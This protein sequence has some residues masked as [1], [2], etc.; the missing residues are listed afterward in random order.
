MVSGTITLNIEPQPG[1][2]TDGDGIP[3]VWENAQGL[4]PYDPEDAEDD[5]NKDGISNLD[6]YLAE[7]EVDNPQDGSDGTGGT[8]TTGDDKKGDT[9]DNT[10]PAPLTTIILDDG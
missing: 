4:D 2:D 8:D 5:R 6:E 7:L 1:T 9:E 3:D 10:T